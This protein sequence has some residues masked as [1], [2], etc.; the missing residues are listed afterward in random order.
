MIFDLSDAVSGAL[1]GV[2]IGAA[3]AVLLLGNGLIAGISGLTGRAL[4]GG[5]AG[6]TEPLVFLAGLIAAPLVY[7]ALMGPVQIQIDTNP[8][9]LIASGLIVGLGTTL[10]NGCTSGHGVCGMSRLS[11][12]SIAATLTFMA[13]A[14]A[15]V[16]LLR[17]FLVGG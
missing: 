1:G 15:T 14:I 16:A 8:V 13:S 6:R 12:R 2:L 11:G 5:S 10:G 4:S 3:A 17:P 7:V 9:L